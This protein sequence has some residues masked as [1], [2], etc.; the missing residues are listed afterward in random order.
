MDRGREG[1]KE[2]NRWTLQLSLSRRR[3]KI[4]TPKRFSRSRSFTRRKRFS[5]HIGTLLHLPFVAFLRKGDIAV[6]CP[7]MRSYRVPSLCPCH[8]LINN[9]TKN[10]EYRM[11]L[12]SL[13]SASCCHAGPPTS[14]D[15]SFFSLKGVSPF[16]KERMDLLEKT[17]FFTLTPR[18]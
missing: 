14:Q 15:P 18:I 5:I 9:T 17:F 1:E 12:A 10:D 3:I 6:V 16:K 7:G 13:Y 8:S 11:D 4:Y 2:R